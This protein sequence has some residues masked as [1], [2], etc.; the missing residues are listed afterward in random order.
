MFSFSIFLLTPDQVQVT[1]ALS[2][3]VGR[4]IRDDKY[5]MD[6]LQFMTK[7][8][9]HLEHQDPTPRPFASQVG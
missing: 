1:I 2:A 8:A 9:S 3:L 5:L 6:A 7:A 4:G